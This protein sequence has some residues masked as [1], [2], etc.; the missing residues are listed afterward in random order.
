MYGYLT[1]EEVKNLRKNSIDNGWN[2]L[3]INGA[4][5]RAYYRVC[6]NGNI[7]LKSYDTI[8]LEYVGEVAVHIKPFFCGL[9]RCTYNTKALHIST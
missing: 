8:V 9:F 5:N 2:P 6:D 4:N 3:P 7:Q 1:N